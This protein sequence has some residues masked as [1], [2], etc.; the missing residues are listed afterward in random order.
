MGY[1]IEYIELLLLLYYIV[2]FPV[3][4]PFLASEI[5]NFAS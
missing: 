2:V 5:F 4:Q 1:G 3:S